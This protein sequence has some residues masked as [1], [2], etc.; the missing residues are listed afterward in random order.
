MG[1]FSCLL[2]WA[3]LIPY[4]LTLPTSLSPRTRCTFPPVFPFFP[5][6]SS[7]LQMSRLKLT[8]SVTLPL[9]LQWGRGT[10][11]G[12]ELSPWWLKSAC[13]QSDPF[14]GE[15]VQRDKEV[16]NAGGWKVFTAKKM[17]KTFWDETCYND[18]L[19]THAHTH[20]YK[21]IKLV[22]VQLSN[23]AWKTELKNWTGRQFSQV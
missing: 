5:P 8:L 21:Y 6:P 10:N 13:F 19:Y 4:F 18:C 14:R 11:T 20:I 23:N 12:Q 9:L 2:P 7:P 15:Q 1:N 3:P 17:I 16:G 22:Q